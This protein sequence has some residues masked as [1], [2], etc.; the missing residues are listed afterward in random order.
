MRY[1]ISQNE[2]EYTYETA[3][4]RMAFHKEATEKFKNIIDGKEYFKTEKEALEHA[5]ALFK[6]DGEF[7][8]IWAKIEKDDDIYR[9][10]N[11]WIVADDNN[12]NQAAEYVGM[13]LMYDK[14]RL[15]GII[16][17]NINIDD[18]IAYF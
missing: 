16:I 12:V 10:L 8:L 7:R 1:R 4:K 6:K 11:Q 3:Q 13:A 18:V 5:L 17:D 9:I 15:E 14:V 2:L